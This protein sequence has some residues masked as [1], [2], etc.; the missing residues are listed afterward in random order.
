MHLETHKL[1]WYDYPLFMILIIPVAM[2]AAGIMIITKFR[3][4]D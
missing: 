1:K 3:G 2:V 4:D